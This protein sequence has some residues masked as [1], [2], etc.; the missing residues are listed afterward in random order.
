MV[1]NGEPTQILKK[2]GFTLIELLISV[3]ILSLLFSWGPFVN[4]STFRDY[5][6][7]Q[8][9]DYL[10]NNLRFVQYLSLQQK[11]DSSFGIKFSGNEYSLFENLSSGK[12]EFFRSHPLPKGF[13]ISGPEEITFRKST[14]KPSWNGDIRILETTKKG[15]VFHKREININSEG[16][17]E[18]LK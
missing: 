15:V 17:I 1:F 7:S 5:Q 4:V 8:E 3:A 14:G 2:R 12:T 11:D 9:A 18:I 16:N 6:I 10:V 13:E